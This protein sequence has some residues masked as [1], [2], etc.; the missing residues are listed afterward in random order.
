MSLIFWNVIFAKVKGAVT[1]R[2]NGMDIDIDPNNPTFNDRF[3]FMVEMNGMPSD[4]FSSEFYLNRKYLII[5]QI[6]GL[7][8]R[9]LKQTITQSYKKNYGKNCRPI[10]KW[11]KFSLEQLLIPIG[12][13]S[14]DTFLKILERLITNFNNNRSGLPD[15]I[16]YNDNELFFAEVKS[17]NDRVS[18][19]QRG[20]HSFLSDELNLK[21]ELFL[22]NHTENKIKRLNSS[23]NPNYK[24]VT[25]SF[26]Y[27][28]SKNRENA[29][30][31]VKAQ[32]SFFTKGEGK[33]QIYGAKFQIGD[34]EKLYKILDLTSRWK[35]Q[36]IEID[37]ETIKSTKLRNSLWCF[38]QKKQI[39]A[40]LDHCRQKEY[41]NTPNKFGCK[42]LYFNEIENDRWQISDENFGYIDTNIGE[43]IFNKETINKRIEDQLDRLK[44]CPLL[45]ERKIRNIIKKIPDKINPKNDEYWAFIS[46]NY[47]LW[48]WHEDKWLNRYGDTNFPGYSSMIGVERNA[49]ERSATIQNSKHSNLDPINILDLPK[50]T[51][52]HTMDYTMTQKSPKTTENNLK[53]QKMN[54][55]NL[56]RKKSG[57][58]IATAVYG[59]SQTYQVQVLKLFRD[60]YLK[61]SILGNVFINIYYN[62]S[63]YIVKYMKTHEIMSNL[64][65]MILDKLVN[66]IERII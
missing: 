56:K 21:V 30:E 22:I 28:A 34:I 54:K 65:K 49:K 7:Q 15:L 46:N 31:F 25:I 52:E 6:R 58:F 13:M 40:S 11:D 42:E 33:D 5:N 3:K 26:G 4:F 35:S 50:Y 60:N 8:N 55:T 44:Y 41:D 57:C 18:E 14:N 36:K 48:F 47:E 43:W 45:N 37:G 9:N 51:R 2:V 62:T 16:V 1:E 17:D 27:S 20:W 32:D 10:E 53:S 63:P 24:T 38:R 39:G 59:S 61:K 64:I 29:I 23:Y 19:N 66:L 12:R